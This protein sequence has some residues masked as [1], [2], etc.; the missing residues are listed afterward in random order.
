MFFIGGLFGRYGSSD[1]TV[2]LALLRLFE[3]VV[4]VLPAGSARLALMDRVVA[5][6]L[7]DAERAMPRPQSLERVRGA[8]AALRTKINSKAATVVVER[9]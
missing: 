2:V 9:S 1:L 4:E 8:V 6:A 5:E 7:A 3:T